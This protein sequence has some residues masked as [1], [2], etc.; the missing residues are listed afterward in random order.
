MGEGECLHIAARAAA[1]GPELQQVADFIDGKA[2]VAGA[3]D[4]AEPVHI[5]SAIVAIV[6][7]APVCGRN[8]DDGFV[9]AAHLGRHARRLAG[10]TDLH[11][12]STALDLPMMGR[13]ISIIKSMNLRRRKMDGHEHHHHTTPAATGERVRAP[14][15]GKMVDPA[16]A[17]SAEHDGKTYHFC[18]DGCRTSFVA[19]PDKYLNQKPFEL[20]P[21]KAAAPMAQDHAHHHGHDHS[22]HDHAQPA[23]A[24]PAPAQ[25]GAKY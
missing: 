9:V 12:S 14:V 21:R 8:E 15:C 10:V 22:H 17:V 13:C 24:A 18:C 16:T 20:P 3:T 7:V 1:V 6:G 2:K 23:A 25:A 19:D 4:E 11:F 5:F